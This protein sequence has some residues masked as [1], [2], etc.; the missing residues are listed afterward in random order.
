MSK[1]STILDPKPEIIIVLLVG[2][3]P[4][5]ARLIQKMLA[6]ENSSFHLVYVNQLQAG[7]KKLTSGDV[8][9]VLL[10]LESPDS[11][12]LRSLK[13]IHSKAANVPVIALSD[14]YD[15]VTAIEGIRK[16]LQDYLV[17]G[18]FNGKMLVRA[19]HC[20]IE[21]QRLHLELKKKAQESQA[22]KEFLRNLIEQ[23]VDGIIIVDK[24]GIV[25]YANLAAGNIFGRK[26]EEFQGKPF[27]FPIAS[28]EKTELDIIRKSGEI[29]TAEMQG[30][31]TTWD[32]KGAYLAS[33]HDITELKRQAKIKDEFIGIVSHELRT[34]LSIIKEAVSLILEGSQGK[35]NEQ[36][37]EILS[38]AKDNVERLAR[39]I[40]DLLDLTK[41]EADKLSLRKTGIDLTKTIKMIASSFESKAKEKG[42]ELRIKCPEK[43]LEIYVDEDRII[44]VLANLVNNAIKFTSRGFIQISAQERE[45][46]VVCAVSDTGIG[47]SK[48]DLSKVFDKFR[49]VGRIEG[50]VEKST[51]LGLTITKRIVELHKGKIWVR[52]E[53]GKGT[54][55]SFSLPKLSS[56][57]VFKEYLSSVI[58]EAKEE[59]S[60]FSVIMISVLNF[61]ELVRSSRE[62]AKGTLEKMEE[63]IRN[64]LRRRND[65]AIKNIKE[66]L[67]ILPETG[68]EEAVSVMGRIEEKLRG[69]LST[70]KGLERKINFG[71]GVISYPD[72]AREEADILKGVRKAIY[73]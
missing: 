6:E 52:S 21:R 49:Q 3:K 39:I 31:K 29:L 54:R 46:T 56:E 38:I 2:K 27:G 28:G 63:V 18:Q 36:Q 50:S 34:P 1:K 64:S 11:Q 9:L 41:I 42:L 4:K 59:R 23:N 10:D 57:E 43:G 51:G 69:Y 40:N 33:L 60:Y 48:E 17:K 71:A 26:R 7:L 53:V 55:F 70:Q 45:N 12:G 30:I 22:S 68:K 44:Q 58:K 35:I 15:E 14:F 5:D 8:D 73:G 25:R 13:K 47:I 16:G 24:N 62:K 32:G 66:I 37:D 72:E 61:R 67:L 20:A 19:I 65:I